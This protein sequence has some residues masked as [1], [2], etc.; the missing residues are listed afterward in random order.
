MQS[1]LN[2]VVTPPE[3]LEKA[4]DIANNQNEEKIIH[5]SNLKFI[6]QTEFLLLKS[7]VMSLEHQCLMLS[8]VTAVLIA[9]FVKT[10]VLSY[11]RDFPSFLKCVGI[12]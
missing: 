12:S 6:S 4:G 5:I 10:S 2:R 3:A 8:P 1:S 11:V 7:E 9:P